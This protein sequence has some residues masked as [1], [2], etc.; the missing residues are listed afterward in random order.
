MIEP[1]AA[2][3]VLER[4]A[5]RPESFEYCR[6]GSNFSKVGEFHK[7]R[8]WLIVTVDLKRDGYIILAKDE[9]R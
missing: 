1:R 8:V 2:V 4:P 9:S 5:Q 7:R 6:D 3:L